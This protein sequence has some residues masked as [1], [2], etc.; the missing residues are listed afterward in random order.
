MYAGEVLN[1]QD[2]NSYGKKYGDEYL[3]ESDL[4]EVVETLKLDYESEVEDIEQ[5]S[6][7]AS[8]SNKGTI[9]HLAPRII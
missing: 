7:V 3:T 2:A 8:S 9:K 6:G 5:L 4:I 1:D